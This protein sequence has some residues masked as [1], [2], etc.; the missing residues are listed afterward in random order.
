VALLPRLSAA[1]Q[2]DDVTEAQDATDQAILFS[3]ALT[4]P[5]AAALTC[6]PYYLIDGLW[7]RGLFTHEDALQSA[8]ALFHYG[9]GVPA[10]VLIRVLQPAYFARQDTRSPMKY[11][12]I[13]VAVNIALGIGLFRLIGVPGIAAATAI[14]SWLTVVQLAVGLWRRKTYRPGPAALARLVRIA[15]ASVALGAFLALAAHYRPLIEA[16]L[17][18]FRFAGIG[19]KE[20]TVVG[21]VGLGAI[22]YVVFLFAFRGLTPSEVRASLRR[23]R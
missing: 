7:A 2:T 11:G 16:P 12:L 9:W 8:K 18:G 13:S 15:L 14:A 5:A 21:V 17:A 19:A 20:I 1:V 22:L 10:F 23:K 6:M 4:L 3:L